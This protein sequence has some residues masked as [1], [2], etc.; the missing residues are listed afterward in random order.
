[1]KRGGKDL[2]HVK[3]N[4]ENHAVPKQNLKDHKA[5]DFPS[6]EQRLAAGSCSPCALLQIKRSILKKLSLRIRE[7]NE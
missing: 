5:D 4:R 3:R 1:V 7:L 6:W 2:S